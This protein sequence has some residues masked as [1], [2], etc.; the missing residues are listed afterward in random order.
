MVSNRSN[1]VA[2]TVNEQILMQ[3]LLASRV[4][5]RVAGQF[6]SIT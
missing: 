4:P 6:H 2:S 5:V 3:D 1:F